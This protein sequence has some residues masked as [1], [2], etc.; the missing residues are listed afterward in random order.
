V[1]ILLFLVLVDLED[2]VRDMRPDQTPN[3]VFTQ[4]IGIDAVEEDGDVVDIGRQTGKRSI[5]LARMLRDGGLGEFFERGNMADQQ[6]KELLS[7]CF[8]VERR[9]RVRNLLCIGQDLLV[10]GILRR[11]IVRR[12]VQNGVLN[13]IDVP[14]PELAQGLLHLRDTDWIHIPDR[15]RFVVA[16][17]QA[18]ERED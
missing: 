15:A 17:H 5:L 16:T 4:V 14:E 11:R 12:V 10:G 7:P 9:H 8:A 3:S 1:R 13:S 6:G 2:M 18:T